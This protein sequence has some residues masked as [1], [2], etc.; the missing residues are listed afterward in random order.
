M[1]TDLELD[2]TRET[3]CDFSS[4]SVTVRTLWRLYYMTVSKEFGVESAAYASFEI[5]VVRFVRD[6]CDTL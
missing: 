5:S 3:I 2:G 1:P 4:F 6:Y